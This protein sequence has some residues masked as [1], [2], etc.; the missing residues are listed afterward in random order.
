MLRAGAP[1]WVRGAKF[2]LT[3]FSLAIIFSPTQYSAKPVDASTRIRRFDNRLRIS[4]EAFARL[5]PRDPIVHNVHPRQEATGKRNLPSV[6]PHSCAKF[7]NYAPSIQKALEVFPWEERVQ[8]DHLV[9][10]SLNIFLAICDAS[11]VDISDCL[12]LAGE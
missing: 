2:R 3:V 5:L 6:F 9:L 12:K 10:L 8:H 11:Q 4:P 7:R 1:S